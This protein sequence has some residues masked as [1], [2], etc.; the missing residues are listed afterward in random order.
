MSDLHLDADPH[1][2]DDHP[3]CAGCGDEN[4]DTILESP[5]RWICQECAAE[6]MTPAELRVVTEW[7]G[8]RQRDVAAIL[9]A[10][11]RTV[12]AWLA[13]KYPI[14]DGVREQ[15]EAIEA[16]TALSVGEVVDAL[17]DARDP[18]IVIYR[19]DEEMW[20]DDA[21][22]RPYP[23]GWWRMVAA[24]AAHEVPGVSII[25]KDEGGA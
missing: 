16:E 21:D 11:E 12:R 17:K 7:L 5:G 19:T 25:F 24:R 10:H 20:A 8:L 3:D 13:G 6:V 4:A 18:T 9:G 22:L 1:Y 15:I 14:P 2:D 23:A